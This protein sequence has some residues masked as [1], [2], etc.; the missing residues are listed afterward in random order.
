MSL[1]AASV[2]VTSTL[3]NL[4][5]SSRVQAAALAEW[6]GLLQAE[7]LKDRRA[8]FKGDG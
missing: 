8:G 2:D 3:R 6:V 5:A 1:K 7:E 4:G